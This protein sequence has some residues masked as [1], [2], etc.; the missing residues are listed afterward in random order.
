VELS[1]N[2]QPQEVAAGTTIAGLLQQLQ[3]Q[4]RLVAVECNRELI[5]RSRHAECELQPG[6]HVEIVTLVGGG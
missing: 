6:D 4:P 2:G 3:K 5:P 1:V